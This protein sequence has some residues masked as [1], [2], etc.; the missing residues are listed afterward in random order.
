[1]LRFKSHAGFTLLE[2]LVVIV[3]MALSV[4][5]VGPS[6]YQ[7]IEKSKQQAALGDLDKQLHYV[8]QRAYYAK[9]RHGILFNGKQLFVLE[10]NR[11]DSP[12]QMLSMRSES[13]IELRQRALS[14]R[15]FDDI[16]FPPA[17]VTFNQLGQPSLPFVTLILNEKEL[18]IELPKLF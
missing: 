12:E 13:L 5:L 14:V 8:S 17:Y 9:K 18:R 10:E 16:F 7:Q 15:E 2:L 4:S 6:L 3:L 1:M 11:E